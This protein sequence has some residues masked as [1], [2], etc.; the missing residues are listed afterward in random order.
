VNSSA[1]VFGANQHPT[2][3]HRNKCPNGPI[4]HP[5]ERLR[6]PQLTPA[7]SH[8]VHMLFPIEMAFDQLLRLAGRWP[9]A[10]EWLSRRTAPRGGVFRA[11]G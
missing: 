11:L 4:R 10:L 9:A 8:L 5:Q 3:R 7:N 1:P 6:N 2:G